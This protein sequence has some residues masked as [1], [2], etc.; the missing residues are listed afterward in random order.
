MVI[1][2]NPQPRAENKKS[3]CRMPNSWLCQTMTMYHREAVWV[4]VVSTIVICKCTRKRSSYVR[5]HVAGREIIE[6][7]AHCQPRL[8]TKK[9]YTTLR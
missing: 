1:E 2:G 4:L 6:H 3:T 8:A 7:V 9:A 5:A